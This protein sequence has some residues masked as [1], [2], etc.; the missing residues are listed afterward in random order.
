MFD[1]GPVSRITAAVYIARRVR[2]HIVS[3]RSR[4]ATPPRGARATR[5]RRFS[6]S[7]SVPV[8]KPPPD[9]LSRRVFGRFERARAP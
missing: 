8:D 4:R 2:T 1:A 9:T 7:K 5:T 6:S 3:R